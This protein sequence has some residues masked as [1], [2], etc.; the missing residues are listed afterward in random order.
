MTATPPITKEER[1]QALACEWVSDAGWFVPAY[2]ARV[3]ELEAA[4]AA[5]VAENAKLREALRWIADIADKQYEQD[6]KLRADGARTLKR[7][8]DRARAAYGESE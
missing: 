1:E 7:L 8:S 2:E 6:E 3:K 4:L 5:E